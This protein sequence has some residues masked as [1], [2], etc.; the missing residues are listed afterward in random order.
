MTRTYLLISILLF[1]LLAGCRSEP[2]CPLEGSWVVSELGC[3]G[4]S[5]GI[6]D[7]IDATYTFEGAQGHTRWVLPGCTVEA[8]FEV[9][10]DGAEVRVRERQHT[11]SPSEATGGDA[12]PCC[13]SGPVDLSLS[14]TC[15]ASREGLG[16]LAELKDEG[17]E[18]PWAGR[19]PWRGCRPGE[20][21]MM[22]LER[23]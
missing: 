8:Q 21:G 5:G 2:V 16:W 18:G 3:S 7:P 19:G 9:Q 12:F 20:V 17:P 10:T 1:G 13:E 11:C 6:P 22:K 15:R 4:G 14:Y 23:R